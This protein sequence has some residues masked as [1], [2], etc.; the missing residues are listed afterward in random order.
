M[1]VQLK[2]TRRYKILTSEVVHTSSSLVSCSGFSTCV[3]LVLDILVANDYRK[4]GD[5]WWFGVT[6]TVLVISHFL[7][8][9]MVCKDERRP[10]SLRK[11]LLYVL[12][13]R[14]VPFYKEFKCWKQRYHTP[15]DYTCENSVNNQEDCCCTNCQQRRH[16]TKELNK[17]AYNYARLNHIEQ[18]TECAPQWCLQVYITSHHSCPPI[19]TLLL[20]ISGV[21]LLA[22]SNTDLEKRRAVKKERTS[23]FTTKNQFWFFLF[24][25]INMPS[26]LLSI[27]V[28]AYA[29]HEWVFVILAGHWSMCLRLL[30]HFCKEENKFFKKC[31]YPSFI[32][33]FTST[34]YSFLFPPA[35]DNRG[36]IDL[37][38]KKIF[39]WCYVLILL[40]N[41]ILTI[42]A[43]STSYIPMLLFILALSF[44]L[45]TPFRDDKQN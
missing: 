12:F 32:F 34:G 9:C 39:L 42:V 33:I 37:E 25:L 20:I 6:V 8:I 17:S 13:P 31:L 11:I 28:V 23:D 44:A 38:R 5:K 30:H 2:Y 7:M 26:R 22:W 1:L 43:V 27:V 3:D 45:A 4:S 40:E 18:I 10:F 21:F 19:P 15:K 35:K 24:Q 16:D 14:F 41:I 36:A 29:F